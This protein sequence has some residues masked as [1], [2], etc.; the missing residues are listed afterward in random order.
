MIDNKTKDKGI[1]VSSNE[2]RPV[3]LKE[4]ENVICNGKVRIFDKVD[5]DIIYFKDFSDIQMISI[6]NCKSIYKVKK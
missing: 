3:I 6:S 2:C 5:G 4:N 1:L